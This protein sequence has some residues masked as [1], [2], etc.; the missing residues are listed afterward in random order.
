MSIMKHKD[1]M[2]YTL[3]APKWTREWGQ[4]RSSTAIF[5][6]VWQ[7]ATNCPKDCQT[8]APS[9]QLRPQP[10]VWRWTITNTWAQVHHDVVVYYDSMSFL[11]AITGEDTDNPF[12][13]HIMNLLWL[14]SDK[15]TR[16]RFCWIPSHCGIDANERVDQLAK[17]PSTK[18]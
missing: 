16:V 2:K 15:I 17:R 8:T 6:M 5:R 18:I 3:M 13:C 10:S 14:L 11:Q 1:H 9:F 12:I 4:Q 7:P